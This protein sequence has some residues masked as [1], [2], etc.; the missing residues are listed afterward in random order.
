MNKFF[1]MNIVGEKLTFFSP[2]TK[3][4]YELEQL[5]EDGYRFVQGLPMRDSESELPIM[6]AIFEEKDAKS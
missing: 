4:T 6:I 2:R 1:Y 5:N 3:L